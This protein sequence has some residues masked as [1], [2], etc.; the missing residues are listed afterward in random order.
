MEENRIV[1]ELEN[2]DS[3]EEAGRRT[4]AVGAV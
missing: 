2:S 4:A 3:P 1:M